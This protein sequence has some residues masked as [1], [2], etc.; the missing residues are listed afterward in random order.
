MHRFVILHH[1]FPRDHP[2]RSHW[3]LMLEFDGKLKTWALDSQPDYEVETAGQRLADHRLQYLEYEGPISNERGSV[4]RFDRGHFE[5]HSIEETRTSNVYKI[6][7]SGSKLTVDVEIV[8]SRAVSTE[9]ANTGREIKNDNSKMN[10]RFCFSE[11]I[12]RNV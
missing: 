1:E 7:L 5:I 2:R 6:R 4:A 3:D 9:D 12:I 10:C 8:E 11:K